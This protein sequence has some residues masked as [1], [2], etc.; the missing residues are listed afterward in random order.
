MLRLALACDEG[1]GEELLALYQLLE[2]LAAHGARRVQHGHGDLGARQGYLG[3]REREGSVRGA[4]GLGTVCRLDADWDL[5]LGGA[6]GNGANV[7]A[8]GGHSLGEGG[9]GGHQRCD[10]TRW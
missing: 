7:D 4:Q 1:F 2:E 9:A 10:H 8:R 6:L 5:A 3:A